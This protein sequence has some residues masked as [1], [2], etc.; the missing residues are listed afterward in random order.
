MNI[1]IIEGIIWVFMPLMIT[2]LLSIVFHFLKLTFY[3][4]YYLVAILIGLI[5]L[6]IAPT[7]LCSDP[8]EAIYGA[9]TNSFI[10]SIFALLLLIGIKAFINWK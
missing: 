10:F 8:V 5:W 7:C 6:A 9:L 4:S 1:N 2:L 3:K